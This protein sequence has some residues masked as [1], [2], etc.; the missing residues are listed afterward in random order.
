MLLEI[1]RTIF[2]IHHRNPTTLPSSLRRVKVAL[3]RN[4]WLA[5]SCVVVVQIVPTS[6]KRTSTI[7]P[8]A[9]SFS[10]SPAGLRKYSWLV[11]SAWSVIADPS[12]ALASQGHAPCQRLVQALEKQAG[13]ERFVPVARPLENFGMAERVHGVAVAGPPMLLHRAP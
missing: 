4:T 3:S 10:I 11:K 2:G 9:R 5:R 12:R 8:A 13:D 1:V 6:G 7:G